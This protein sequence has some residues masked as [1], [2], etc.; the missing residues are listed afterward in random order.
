MQPQGVTLIDSTGMLLQYDFTNVAPGLY[1]V[2]A[3]KPTGARA[4]LINGFRLVAGGAAQLQT[5]VM[6]PSSIAPDA[7]GSFHMEFMN[8][9]CKGG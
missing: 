6:L 8:A 3:F 2:V 4:R 5:K 1:D 9:G 7:V